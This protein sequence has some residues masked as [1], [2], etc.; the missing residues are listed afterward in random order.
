MNSKSDLDKISQN[1]F[2][3]Q[4]SQKDNIDVI[5]LLFVPSNIYKLSKKE[6]EDSKFDSKSLDSDKDLE[7][8]NRKV[9][10][11]EHHE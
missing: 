11:G 9:N 10:K 3:P 1:N 4:R 5:N 2:D 6:P 8:N 7:R